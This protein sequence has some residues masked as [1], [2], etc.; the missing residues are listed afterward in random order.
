MKSKFVAYLLWFFLGVFGAH[1]F[2]CGKIGTG[3]LWFFTLG[4]FGIGWLF[5][6][7]LTSGMVDQANLKWQLGQ[8]RFAGNHNQNNINIV[9]D[10]NALSGQQLVVNNPPINTQG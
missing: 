3:I 6:L 7:I 4:F 8:M 1:R 2:Y 5:D 10:P 9:L